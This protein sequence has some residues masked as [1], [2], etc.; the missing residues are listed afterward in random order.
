[1]FPVEGKYVLIWTYAFYCAFLKI[2][3]SHSFEEK[4]W[5][6]EGHAEKICIRWSF[7]GLLGLLSFF[8]SPL[9][10]LCPN[11]VRIWICITK[12]CPYMLSSS[13]F[14][15]F[16][17]I[18][19]RAVLRSCYHTKRC[20]SHFEVLTQIQ[21]KVSCMTFPHLFWIFHLGPINQYPFH[22]QEKLYINNF[23]SM[24]YY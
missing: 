24:S 2:A 21:Y 7:Q 18:V 8:V 5:F 13:Q 23:W 14:G 3:F 15:L 11:T 16:G 4:I 10:I 12:I 17:L 9:A 20:K 19:V 1:M 22:F 6:R